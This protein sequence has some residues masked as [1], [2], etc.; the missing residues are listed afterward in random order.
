MA[1][2]AFERVRKIAV[3]A[4]DGIGPEVIAP[5]VELLEWYGQDRGMPIEIWRLDLGAERYL[6][7]GTALSDELLNRIRSEASAVLLGA[8][9]DP[10]IPDSAHARSIVLG[11]R[12]GLDLYAN[13]RPVRALADRLLPLRDKK[14][15]DVDFVV[16]REN[17]EG[18]YAGVGE[19]RDRGTANEVSVDHD[20][21]TRRAVERVLRAGFEIAR[22]RKRS[23]LCL[24]DKSNA[25]RYGQELWRR[26]FTEIAPE[27]PEVESRAEY[28]D[29]LCHHLILD[30]AKY[31]VIVTNN[32]FGDVV[33]DI[34]AALQGGLGMAPSANLR[35]DAPGAV[36]LFEPVHGSAPNLAGSDRANPFAALLSTGLMLEHLG[37]PAERDRLRRAVST[38]LLAGRCTADVGGELGTRAAGDAVLTLIARD[39]I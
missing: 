17:T 14:L 12:K 19:Q 11:L 37:W 28:I 16:V 15:A 39:F 8:I 18:A 34:G 2:Q 25:M 24:A 27:Y 7:D 36:A 38:A 20:V 5:C 33:S 1:F 4:G 22:S 31:D 29:A 21:N 13:V 10:R 32:L 35:W 26:V 3:I 9:G 23:S 6:K 30:P